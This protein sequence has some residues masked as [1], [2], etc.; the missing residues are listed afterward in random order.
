MNWIQYKD[1]L[2]YICLCSLVVSSLS[3]K[4]EILSSNPTMLIFYF[5]LFLFD[6]ESSEFSDNIYRKL[7]CVLQQSFKCFVYRCFSD[8]K[9]EFIQGNVCLLR[10]GREI[11]LTVPQKATGLK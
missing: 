4:Q 9:V 11:D 6:T 7:H 1:L 2:C 3:L 5:I 10:E 8:E